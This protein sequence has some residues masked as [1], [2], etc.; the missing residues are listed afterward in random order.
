MGGVVDLM[1]GR[2][3]QML[4]MASGAESTNR[5]TYKIPTRGLLGLRNSI[6]TATKARA[7]GGPLLH[8]PFMYHCI[9]VSLS[10]LCNQGCGPVAAPAAHDAE[11]FVQCIGMH[12]SMGSQ[13][14]GRC[15]KRYR[16]AG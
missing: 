7:G 16:L 15:C 13:R 5:V 1:G 3:G 9:S 4:D 6:L 12:A 8:A 10:A 2:K 14:S 11:R